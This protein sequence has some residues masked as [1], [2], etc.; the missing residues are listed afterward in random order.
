[1]RNYY[2]TESFIEAARAV[3]HDKYDYS[4]VKFVGVNKKVSIICPEHG[5]F[6][7]T[8]GKHL[9]GQGCPR[10]GRNRTKLGKEEFIKRAREIH[11]DKY[12]YSKAVYS[13]VDQPVEII[14]PIHGPFMQTP[15]EHIALK[16]NCPKCGY[17]S[18]GKKRMGEKNVAHRLDVKAAKATAFLERYGAKTWAES[19]AGRKRLHEIIV[20]EGKLDKM[21]QTCQE[22][23]GTDFWTQCDEGRA[24]LHE[25]MSSDEMRAKIVAGY[26][27]AYGMHYMQTE[28]GRERARSYIDDERREKM[29]ASL[30]A[31]Y[32][33]P[34]VVLTDEERAKMLQKSWQTKRRNGTFNTSKPEDT[35]YGLLCDIFGEEDVETQYVDDERYPFHCDFYVKSLDLF[36]ELN[37]HW[38]H[39]GHW[40]DETNP[41]DI[42]L[43]DKWMTR[44]KERGSAYYHEAITVWTQRDLLKREFAKENE[45]NYVVFWKNDLSDAREYLSR[46]K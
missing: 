6:E 36:I 8:P 41:D 23:Y 37:A 32:G 1:M 21:K 22:R 12:D 25:K 27:A 39:G 38:S 7:Q 45:L 11:G 35:L 5:V 46:I 2:T 15:R 17:A 19:D 16:H 40:F 13:R 42:A 44:A 10:C 24:A 18:A 4:D 33:V 14:C 20:D 43:L 3:H 26:K 28:Q 30:T 34:Y 9:K 29:L 31:R